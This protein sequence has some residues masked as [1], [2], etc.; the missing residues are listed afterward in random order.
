MISIIL[1]PQRRKP[2]G[3]PLED[4]LE[5]LPLQYRTI[6]AI[7]Y[8]TNSKIEDILFLQKQDITPELILIRDSTLQKVKKVSILAQLQPYLTVFLNGYNPQKSDLL[9]TDKEGNPLKSSQVFKIL[10]LVA[11]KIN[12]PDIYWLIL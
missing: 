5:V 2:Q 11:N 1:P 9:F 8:F 10:K 4:F 7:A 6:V 12:L 3:S